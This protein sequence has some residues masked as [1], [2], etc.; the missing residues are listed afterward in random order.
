M[1]AAVESVISD[2]SG[3]KLRC[4]QCRKQLD[5]DAFDLHRDPNL[6]VLSEDGLPEWISQRIEEV[7]R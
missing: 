2:T 4:A 6:I 3:P 1:A 7:T 5:I